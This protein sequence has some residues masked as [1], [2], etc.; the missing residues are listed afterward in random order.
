LILVDTNVL[1]AL[2]DERDGLASRAERDLKRLGAGPFGLTGPVLGEACFLLPRGYLRRRL[3][4]LLAR[5]GVAFVDVPSPFWDDVFDWMDRYEEH[6]PD[7]A[8]AQ[9]AV[10]CSRDRDCRIWT[11]DREFRTTWRRMDGS[12]IPLAVSGPR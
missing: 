11:Y 5:L 10:L 7:L 6:E 3:W 9:M 12:R 8:D 1:V 2:A 4:F